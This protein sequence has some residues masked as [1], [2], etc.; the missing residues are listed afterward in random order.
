M[1]MQSSWSRRLAA[2]IAVPIPESP[3]RPRARRLHHSSCGDFMSQPG[4]TTIFPAVVSRRSASVI[5]V[6]KRMEPHRPQR[7]PLLGRR[8][9]PGRP[10]RAAMGKVY[11]V[12]ASIV[13]II[14]ACGVPPLMTFMAA[15]DCQTSSCS[16]VRNA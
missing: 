9:V 11:R 6:M 14:S 8:A 13:S 1:I 12:L 3:W 7:R 4:L 16:L 2:L 5:S 15:G 10:R